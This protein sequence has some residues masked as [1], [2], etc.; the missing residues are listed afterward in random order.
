MS[1]IRIGLPA[2]RMGDIVDYNGYVSVCPNSE[3]QNRYLFDILKELFTS[4]PFDGLY[5]NM[6]S[7]YL[8]DYNGTFHGVCQ[9]DVCRGLYKK[10]TGRELP[11]LSTREIPHWRI[12]SL[13]WADA[14]PATRQS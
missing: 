12:I 10:E 1:S 5:C 3:Y 9:C 13:F 7:F 6:S 8:T 2:L 4:H 11:P 14:V